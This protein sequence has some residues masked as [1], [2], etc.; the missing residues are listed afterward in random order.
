[1]SCRILP[2]PLSGFDYSHLSII[3]RI[4]AYSGKDVELKT[5]ITKNFSSPFPFIASPMDTV[6]S[7]DLA[8]KILE[9]QGLPILHSFYQNVESLYSLVDELKELFPSDEYPIGILIS[10]NLSKLKEIAPLLNHGIS[11]VAFDTLHQSPHLHLEA[12][13]RFKDQFPEVEVISGNV[14]FGEDCQELVAAGADVIRIGMTSASINRGRELLGCGRQQGSAIWDCAKVTSELGVP[15][16]ADGGIKQISEAIIA[17]A[18]GADAVMMGQMFA[19]LP[20]S[21]AP[22]NINPDGET[23]KIY[24]GMSRKG[25]IDDELIPEGI[26]RELVIDRPFDE[27]VSRWL[28]VLKLAISRAGCNSLEDFKTSAY[29]EFSL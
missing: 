13:Q 28:Q 5:R 8:I 23:V 3:P 11:V 21:A 14:V 19:R 6:I 4:S 22:I 2:E 1:M 10:P 7:K 18:L 9:K 20:E 12:V 27:A 16:I 24:Q 25:K 29:L 17:L 26:I 15:L